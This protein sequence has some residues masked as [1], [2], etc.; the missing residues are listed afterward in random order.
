MNLALTI[1]YLEDTAQQKDVETSWK[2][3]AD[4]PLL[5]SSPKED[6]FQHYNDINAYLFSLAVCARSLELRLLLLENL[7]KKKQSSHLK[8]ST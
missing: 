5:D 3:L 8:G 4:V 2:S 1:V 7:L 6:C